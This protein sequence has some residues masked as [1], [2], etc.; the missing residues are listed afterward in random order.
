MIQLPRESLATDVQVEVTFS[1]GLDGML[2][3]DAASKSVKSDNNKQ[4]SK[5]LETFVRSA[6]FST[7]DLMA[8]S[9][10]L[11]YNDEPEKSWVNWEALG[12]FISMPLATLIFIVAAHFFLEAKENGRPPHVNAPRRADPSAYPNPPPPPPPPRL[13]EAEYAAMSVRELKAAAA[14]RNVNIRGLF[15]KSEIVAKLAWSS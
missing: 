1:L 13:S 12:Y 4:Y 11:G 6:A 10:R 15:E 2:L 14:A 5:S 7:I 9:Q 8:M 3:V